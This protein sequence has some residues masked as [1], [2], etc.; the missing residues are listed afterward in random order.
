M[1][2]C[3]INDCTGFKTVAPCCLYCSERDV[4]PDRCPKM[5][6]TNC[7]KITEN[8]YKNTDSKRILADVQGSTA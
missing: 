7:G 1:M 5:D 6:N 3:R 8:E 4:C 2:T